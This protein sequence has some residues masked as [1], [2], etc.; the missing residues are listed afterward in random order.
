M[1]N[2][3]GP[4][5]RRW[6]KARGSHRTSFGGDDMNK[7]NMKRARR[8]TLAI[9]ALG[10]WCGAILGA[11]AQDWPS[12]PVKFIVPL[13]PG[14]GTDIGARLMAEQLTKLWGQSVV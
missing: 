11:N 6:P 3:F 1:T 10:L 5:S 12:R 14:S 4:S 9:A 8:L 13:G 7:L 2:S